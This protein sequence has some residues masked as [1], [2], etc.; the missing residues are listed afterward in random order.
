MKIHNLTN[1]IE[2]NKKKEIELINKCNS[3]QKK[4]E[5]LIGH[6]NMQQNKHMK[7]IQQKNNE[8]MQ[9]KL[10]LNDINKTN[11]N[12]EKSLDKLEKQNEELNGE[13]MENVNKIH[14][15]TNII[16]NNKKKEIE[17]I[18]KCNSVREV[19]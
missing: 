11:K 17:L 6:A 19:L 5:N 7:Q 18:N 4:N 12:M 10:E 13:Q 15:L 9:Q 14:N 16:E 8:I 1:I 2:N 3:F